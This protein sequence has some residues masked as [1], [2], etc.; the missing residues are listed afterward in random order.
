MAKKVVD[1]DIKHTEVYKKEYVK[2][3]HKYE[4]LPD[5]KYI[6][7]ND[8]SEEVE[9][10]IA[11]SVLHWIENQMK[12]KYC[13]TIQLIEVRFNNYHKPYVSLWLKNV[14]DI[15]DNKYRRLFGIRSLVMYVD[16]LGS[17]NSRIDVIL[18]IKR[19]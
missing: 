11:E 19:A 13:F 10:K 3:Y 17:R 4:D 12:P 2:K 6:Y 7:N 5:F 16:S 14:V 18:D 15:F 1:V 8:E 9:R